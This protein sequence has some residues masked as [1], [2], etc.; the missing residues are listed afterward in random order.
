MA[1]TALASAPG[2]LTSLLGRRAELAKAS[3]W[4][5][6]GDSG[7]PPVIPV[8]SPTN[9]AELLAIATSP[10]VSGEGHADA[11]AR[12]ERELCAAFARMDAHQ[13]FALGRRLDVAEVSD[14]LAAAFARLTIDRQRRLRAFLRELARQLN[15]SATHRA[16]NR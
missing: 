3:I 2:S 11:F 16:S 8:L 13:V 7:P 4:E 10:R 1:A 6:P 9:E 12:K 5:P 14:H 15:A